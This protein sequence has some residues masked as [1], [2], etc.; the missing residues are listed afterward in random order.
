MKPDKERKPDK[1]LLTFAII[2]STFFAVM[3]I[4]IIAGVVYS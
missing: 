1:A 2:A 3:G 4:L